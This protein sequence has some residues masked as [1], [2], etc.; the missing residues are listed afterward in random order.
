MPDISLFV[1]IINHGLDTEVDVKTD[2]F[3]CWSVNPDCAKLIFPTR[4]AR[5][6]ASKLQIRWLT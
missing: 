1:I 5:L 4:L 6:M 3:E 2:I